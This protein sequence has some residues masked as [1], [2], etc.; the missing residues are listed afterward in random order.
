[1]KT[2]INQERKVFEIKVIRETSVPQINVFYQV[3]RVKLTSEQRYTIGYTRWKVI[4]LKTFPGGN[5]RAAR[6]L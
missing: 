5:Y 3:A 1:M 4:C 2:R 6:G